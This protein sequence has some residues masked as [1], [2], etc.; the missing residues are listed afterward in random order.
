MKDFADKGMNEEATA[1]CRSVF[2]FLQFHTIFFISELIGECSIIN[3]TRCFFFQSAHAF[4]AFQRKNA[5]FTRFAHFYT[6]Q[7]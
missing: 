5:V 7:N 2:V 3:C 6:P 1:K 4:S